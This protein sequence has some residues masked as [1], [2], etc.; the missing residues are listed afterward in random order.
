MTTTTPPYA[1]SH[2]PHSDFKPRYYIL[3]GLRGVA[4]MLVI[5]YHFFEGF[6]TSPTDQ[7]MNHG[8]LAVDFFFV[9][10]GFVIGY[11]YDN[12]WSEDRMTSGR[13]LI[14]RIIRLQPMVV[15]SVILGLIA[16]LFQGSVK[17]DGTPVPL[18]T[19]L[20]A[21]LLGLFMIPVL[22]GTETDVRG[23][24]E[25][26][27]LN[28]PSWSLFF[29]YIGSL[30]YALILHKLSNAALRSVVI[31]SGIGLA[32]CAL[33]NMSGAYHL[34]LGWSMADMGWLGGLL[35]LSFSFGM[36]LLL[37]RDFKPRRIRG[38]FWICSAIIAAIMACPYVGVNGLPSIANGVYDTICTIVIFPAI[39]YV[40]AC[41]IT[42]DTFSDKICEFLGKMSYPVY[43]IH[44]PVMYLF[45]AWVWDNGITFAEAWPICAAL[46]AGIIMMAW[47]ALKWYDD[48]VRHYLSSRFTSRRS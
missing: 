16:Y 39:V 4:A 20:L 1:T 5:W 25:M 13:F 23:N 38:A 11:A 24:G 6:A 32:A 19:A 21:L 10:S 44:Y 31:L 45:Y 33:C 22:S 9:L 26:F 43:I 41:G 14:R 40:G 47:M 18:H 35:R 37:I 3:D 2:T 34:G 30:L 29:E 7:M 36:G 8:Y 12:R 17:W 46:F 15:L 42:T 48:P 27:P 28:G